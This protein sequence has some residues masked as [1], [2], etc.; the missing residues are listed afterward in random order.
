MFD[1]KLYFETYFF[2]VHRIPCIFLHVN[3]KLYISQEPCPILES[4]LLVSHILL[5]FHSPNVHEISSKI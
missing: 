3:D 2:Y 4:I 5:L 1:H